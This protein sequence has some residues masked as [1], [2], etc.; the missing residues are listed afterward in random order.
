MQH[1]SKYFEDRKTLITQDQSI[2]T[3]CL[4]QFQYRKSD[5]KAF[6]YTMHGVK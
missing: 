4:I 3:N 5:S 6:S 1:F 2:Q